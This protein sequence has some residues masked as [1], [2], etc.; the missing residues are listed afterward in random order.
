MDPLS[1]NNKAISTGEGIEAVP[2]KSLYTAEGLKK[3]FL[4]NL[5]EERI[6]IVHC[7]VI[8]LFSGWIRVRKDT[9][10]FDHDSGIKK[11]LTHAFNIPVAPEYR[12]VKAGTSYRF[13]LIFGP[14]PDTCEF[15]DLVESAP[16]S[17]AITA[18]SIKRNKEDIYSINIMF[19]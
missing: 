10:L 3:K 1:K 8:L 19:L 6:V 18:Y 15:F 16:L 4:D 5:I 13:T 14:L 11:P 12:E 9:F 2:L 7:S 17:S